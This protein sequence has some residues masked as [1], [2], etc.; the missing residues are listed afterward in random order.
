M[1]GLA[2]TVGVILLLAGCGPSGMQTGAER[3]AG[4]ISLPA[5]RDTGTT[6]EEALR[7]RRSVRQY[8]D[9]PLLLDEVGQLLWACQGVTDRR[10]FRTAP[11]AGALYPL[12]V[13]VAVGQV[14]GLSPGVYRYLPE[15]HSLS[16]LRLGDVRQE[17]SEVALRQPWVAEG[18]AVFVIAADYSRTTA[19]Y[20]QRGVRYVH[21]EVGHAAQNLLL[22]VVALGL[23]AVP[24]GAFNDDAVREVLGLPR[25]QEVLYLIPVGEPR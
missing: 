9:R 1:R 3:P 16:C 23:A 2:A 11:S 14:Q 8:G 24:V 22:Q 21:I 25:E 13:Y 10:G 4:E 19:R 6:L 12:E 15:N 7:R 18:A 17:L 20:G 5:P